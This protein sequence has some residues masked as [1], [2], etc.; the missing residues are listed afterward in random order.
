MRSRLNAI[1]VCGCLL[2]ALAAWSKKQETATEAP[3]PSATGTPV[4]QP[5]QNAQPEQKTQ[6]EQKT[7]PEAAQPIVVPAGTV[8]TV[9]LAQA[10]GSKISNSGDTFT[11]TVANPV[12]VNGATVVPAGAPAEGTVTQAAPLGRFK[13]GAL[14]KLT[15]TS[16]TINGTPHQLQ[17]NAFSRVVTG[18]GK[19]SAAMIGGGAGVG[20]LVGAL[21]GGGKGAAIG[22]LAGA[23]AGTA[24]TALTG[25]KEIVLP[26][27]SAVSFRLAQPLQLRQ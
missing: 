13:G 16:V 27:E 3:G 19:R 22:A 2:V 6:A 5:E 20:A 8:I 17:T 21:A 14:L 7:K 18:K 9:R 11:A 1:M 15:L 12:V 25:N 23:G 26:A 4:T 10:V 24:G